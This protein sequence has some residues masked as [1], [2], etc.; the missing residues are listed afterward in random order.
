MAKFKG[1][2]TGAF[3]HTEPKVRAPAIDFIATGLLK[4]TN[5]HITY[6]WHI[7]DNLPLLAHMG[8][9]KVEQ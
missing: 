9:A 6:D 2:V 8:V 4:V 5:G 7:G 3:G 1:H